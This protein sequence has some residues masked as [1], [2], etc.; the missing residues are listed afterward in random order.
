LAAGKEL[1]QVQIVTQW[2]SYILVGLLVGTFSGLF[3]VGGGV[4]MV[5]LMVIIWKLDPK[6]AIGTSLA[7]MVPTAFFGSIRHYTLRNVD[8]SLA[9]CLSVGAILGTVFIGAPLV[10]VLPSELLKRMFGIVMLISGIQ[11]SGLIPW[12]KAL[13]FRGHA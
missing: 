2:G 11:W 7:A 12:L 13:I 1:A 8:L 6:M 4:L 5:P 9:A 10:K 3:G